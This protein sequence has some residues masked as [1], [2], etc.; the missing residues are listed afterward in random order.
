[1]MKMK[2]TVTNAKIISRES[3]PPTLK[4]TDD[5]EVR[6][7]A[8]FASAI[9]LTSY[10]FSSCH[11]FTW[12]VIVNERPAKR[13]NHETALPATQRYF[14]RSKREKKTFC[15]MSQDSGK[16][17]QLIPVQQTASK[18]NG[19]QRVNL[20]SVSKLMRLPSAR[21]GRLRVTSCKKKVQVRLKVLI[22]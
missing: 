1:M 4:G 21:R 12:Y 10:I 16:R 5:V 20:I 9:L 8:L 15:F 11:S 22:T 2:I 13:A 7:S 17:K 18:G 19:Q 3:P 6:L 14:F